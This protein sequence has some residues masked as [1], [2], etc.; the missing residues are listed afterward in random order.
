MNP[1]RYRCVLFDFDDTI[2]DGATSEREAF[3]ALMEQSGIEL[4]PERFAAYQEINTELWRSVERGERTPAQVNVA[5]FAYFVQQIGVDADPDAMA[6]AYP[7]LLGEYGDLLPGVHEP[8]CE[9][10]DRVPLV[11]VTNGIGAVQRRRIERLDLDEYFTDY[12]ISGEEEVS[13]PDPEI[14]SIALRRAGGYAPEQA[15]MVGDQLIP[16]VGGAHA[17]GIDSVWVNQ[18]KS[19][20]LPEPAPTYTIATLDALVP[21]VLGKD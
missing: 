2:F 16:D 13:K 8:L 18:P 19:G 3:G 4:T 20:L 14:F 10:S 15:L 12:V 1:S 21:I 5:R 6:Q 11:V 7:S 9:L 17:A